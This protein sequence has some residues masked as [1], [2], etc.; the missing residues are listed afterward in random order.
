MAYE[1]GIGGTERKNDNANE[2]FVEIQQNRTL[3]IQKLTADTP[4]EPELVQNLKTIDE[5]F[6]HY[7]PSV[8]VEFETET[9]ASASENVQF[10]N[11]GDFGT[12]GILGQSKFLQNLN[13]KQQ[14][15][16]KIVK[17]LKSN[18]ALRNIMEDQ[19]SKQ[20]FINAV[21]ALIAELE[22]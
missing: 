19:E 4:Y 11:L 13:N 9:G 2:G 16:Q 8:N 5:V 1:Y 20:A 18:K 22:E 7:K 14:Q 21:R 6:Q 12:K 17:E 3:F 15:Y 10:K